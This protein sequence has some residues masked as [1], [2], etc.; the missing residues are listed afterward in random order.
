MDYSITVQV[1]DWRGDLWLSVDR[2]GRV[3]GKRFAP[4]ERLASF[5][6]DAMHDV[7]PDEAL[8]WMHE[9]LAAWVNAGCPR[10]SWTDAKRPRRPLEGAMGVGA[11]TGHQGLVTLPSENSTPPPREERRAER[12]SD[13]L[14]PPGVQQTLW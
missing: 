8:L 12:D 13:G 1:F 6:T 11:P 9:Q 5:H 7:S 2:V 10:R 3:A 14:K 4:R